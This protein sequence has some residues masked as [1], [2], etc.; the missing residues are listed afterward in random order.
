M[1][2]LR[3]LTMLLH[4]PPSDPLDDPQ[5]PPPRLPEGAPPPHVPPER[6]GHAM[7]FA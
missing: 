7:R 3:A 1:P 6:A 5:R 4:L 2:I